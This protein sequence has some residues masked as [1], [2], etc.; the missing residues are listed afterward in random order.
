[1]L[2][3]IS[4]VDQVTL[5]DLSFLFCLEFVWVLHCVCNTLEAA[6]E[7]FTQEPS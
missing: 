3:D 1:M 7:K 6:V 5:E 4:L 2:I